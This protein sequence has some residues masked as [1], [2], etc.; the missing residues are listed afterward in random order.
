MPILLA[1]FTYV[2]GFRS[3]R[4]K[5]KVYDRLMRQINV[6]EKTSLFA[7]KIG[8]G[9]LESDLEAE[10]DDV[11][12][13]ALIKMRDN[14]KQQAI[15]EENRNWIV[16]GVA[17][18]GNILR[19]HN[20]VNELGYEIIK[21]LVPKLNAVQGGFYTV[22]E[23]DGNDRYSRKGSIEQVA[24]FAYNRRK[25]TTKTFE[26]GQGLIG[27]CALE[28]DIIHRKEIPNEFVSITSGLIDEKKPTDIIIVPL[29]SE[30]KIYGI[31]EFA[32]FD[33]FDDRHIKFLKELSEIIA[34]SLFNISTN[35]HTLKL[36]NEVNKSQE[37]TEKLLANASEVIS[38]Y[39]KSGTLKYVSPSVEIIL[40]YEPNEIVGTTDESR[41]SSEGFSEL[42][43]I[44]K[45]LDEFPNE[46]FT[47]QYTYRRA[48]GEE[49]W[50]ETTGRNLYN[51]KAIDGFLFNTTDITERRRAEEQQRERA[52]MQALSENSPD[53]I[54]RIDI[55]GHFS[56]VNPVIKTLTGI[57]PSVVLQNSLET[58]ELDKVIVDKWT[59][60]KN[61]LEENP[62]PLATEMV[63]PTIEGEEL[64]MEVNCIPEFDTNRELESILYVIHDITD[65][66]KA[67]KAIKV[68]NDKVMD[69]I[70]YARR[71]QSSILPKD[72]LLTAMFPKSFMLFKPRDIVSGDYP[73][74]V[75][76]G[77]WAY[78]A[79]VDCTGHGVPGALLSIIGSLLMQEI[80]KTDP[81]AAELN[82]QLHAKVVKAL[83]QGEEGSENERDG[84][85]ISTCKIHMK[86]GTLEYSG[87]HRPLYILRKD[88]NPEEDLEQFKGDK[89]P[90]GGVQYRGRTNFELFETKLDRGDRIFFFSDGY[91]DQFGGP[92]EEEK[93]FGPKRI[94]KKLIKER[95]FEMPKMLESL[96][97]TISKWQGDKE[98]M[99]DILFI[100]IEY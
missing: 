51:N 32:G 4:Q 59:E 84:M 3:E 36:L 18:I 26:F 88:H 61:Q 33:D 66:K 52:K 81:N 90:I 46:T 41:V 10:E 2:F 42:K 17:D 99:D 78:V 74:F 92:F 62:Q 57:E 44:F 79:A 43:E 16:K 85:D 58:I 9:Q 73:F 31:M 5:S 34:R 67:E 11:L 69:S 70:N 8:K 97:T 27:Q 45:K 89:Y 6:I 72:H 23:E 86:D 60:F 71:I 76:R 64:F 14:L 7:E 82:D 80:V 12:G 100:G 47:A 49:I 35:E 65:A 48:N 22:K 25:Y 96:D 77:D 91:P 94:R 53:L 30:G 19:N 20:K 95:D 87:A 98:Q 56:Y 68:A 37:R 13:N 63:F 24:A 15:E 50:L 28:M 40:G 1:L 39:D 29:I 55:Q 21:S 75:Q 93:K 38:I 54:V 83:R